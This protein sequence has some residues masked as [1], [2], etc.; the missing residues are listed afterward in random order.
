MGYPMSTTTAKNQTD[1][2]PYRNFLGINIGRIG[3]EK[4]AEKAIYQN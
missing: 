1:T 2:R 4:K 3:K